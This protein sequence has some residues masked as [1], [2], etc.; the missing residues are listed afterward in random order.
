MTH[1]ELATVTTLIVG[2]GV[3]GVAV[4]EHLAPLEP[5]ALIDTRPAVIDQLRDRF[6]KAA[7]RTVSEPAELEQLLGT[8]P[9]LERAVVSPGLAPDHPLLVLLRDR[10][11]VLK[12][13]I[14][15]FCA[16]APAPVLGCTGTNGKSTV[17]ALTG[18]LLES[19]GFA[20]AVGG[21]LAPAALTLLEQPA[22]VYVL[23][24]SSFQLDR[25]QALP[26][27]AA[28][29]LN[30]ADDHLDYHGTR[31]A[32][33]AAKQ[34]IFSDAAAIAWNAD[35]P[36][37]QPKEAVAAKRCVGF[38]GSVE[39]EDGCGVSVTDDGTRWMT[40]ARAATAE[41]LLPVQDLPLAG[42]HNVA[43]VAAAVTLA[44][45]FLEQRDQPLDLPALRH[46]L[47]RFRGL[48]HRCEA[49]AEVAGV[50]YINDSKAT[51]VAA[52]IA[53]VRG[54]RSSIERQLLV[55]LGGEAKGAELE[56]LATAFRG[57]V[58]CVVT[59]GADGPRFAAALTGVLPVHPE[60]DATAAL[61][62]ARELASAGDLVL[63][64]PAAASFDEFANYEARGDWFRATVQAWQGQDRRESS[65]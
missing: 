19:Q 64:A 50:R 22:D 35:D 14:D 26:L 52:A 58:D 12:S 18:A 55:L 9:A 3:T 4:L 32:Y 10:G 13:D 43:N 29:L 51:N 47:Q 11:V 45:L 63:L 16:V 46:A 17:T 57:T 59:Y 53:A 54:L 61:L 42:D 23:E 5:V 7:L 31:E 56:P 1:A 6:P 25:S 2:G 27:T 15:L 49:V 65:A 44:M 30:V 38:S 24:L 40:L 33:L 8:L 60:P 28:V 41:R 62:R 48:P 36:T 20:V 34:R 39:L 37:T 21:N